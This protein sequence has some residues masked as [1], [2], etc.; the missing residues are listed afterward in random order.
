MVVHEQCHATTKPCQQCWRTV[1]VWSCSDGGTADTLGLNPSASQGRA[2]S[3]PAQSTQVC[4]G[5]IR[6]WCRPVS[7]C[8]HVDPHAHAD[9]G[10]RHSAPL[11][12]KMTRM[13]TVLVGEHSPAPDSVATYC[14]DRHHHRYTSATAPTCCVGR[15][16]RR[17]HVQHQHPVFAR[18]SLVLPHPSGPNCCCGLVCCWRATSTSCHRTTTGQPS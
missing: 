1:R 16:S 14:R 13:G 10:R 11:L 15:H 9:C 8:A 4:I 3:N 5:V 12:D 18:C 2:G 7:I 17:C 6:R